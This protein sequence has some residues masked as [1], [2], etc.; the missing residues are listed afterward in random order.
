MKEKTLLKGSVL[1][2]IVGLLFLFLYAHKIEL[3]QFSPANQLRGE[4]K[5][6]MAGT[7]NTV[8]AI[9]KATFLELEGQRIETTKVIV[10]PAGELFL[11]PGDYIEIAGTVEDYKGE[12]EIIAS[13][14]VKR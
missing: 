1:L 2:M 6:A 9:G 10:F 11:Q 3:K 13:K 5:V 12:K 4:E 7:I 8:K 14:I